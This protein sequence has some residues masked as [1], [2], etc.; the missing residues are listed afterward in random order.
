MSMTNT[1]IKQKLFDI[2]TAMHEISEYIENNQHT[3]GQDYHFFNIATSYMNSTGQIIAQCLK[4]TG[5]EGEEPVYKTT[6]NLG[7]NA[8][9][10]R[11]SNQAN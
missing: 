10:Q 9:G 5:K 11:T 1:E 8:N 4:V 6:N 2:M 7:D 3:I